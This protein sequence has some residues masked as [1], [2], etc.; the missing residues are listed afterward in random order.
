MNKK[1]VIG[2]YWIVAAAIAFLILVV[3]IYFIRG[4][5]AE[6]MV[7]IENIKDVFTNPLEKERL[8]CISLCN[9]GKSTLYRDAD[10]WR[11]SP[12]CMRSA[13]VDLNGDGKINT[14]REYGLPCWYI[15]GAN[16]RC[17]IDLDDGTILTECNCTQ[18]ACLCGDG[19][20]PPAQGWEECDYG[21]PGVG[22]AVGECTVAC[23][24]R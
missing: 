18:N 2:I 20:G 3:M 9:Q 4:G 21:I 16:I 15:G 24:C 10:E 12:Y 7:E 14:S 22:C 17:D 1:G 13:T 23:K 11:T 8:A 19:I 6:G 5:V